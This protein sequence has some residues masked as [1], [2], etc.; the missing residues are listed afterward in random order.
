MNV[1][2]ISGLHGS[3]AFKKRH[4]PQV[5]AREAGI[6]FGLDSAAA[7]VTNDDVVAAAAEE[8]FTREKATGAFPKNA[9]AYCIR[10][11]GLEPERIDYLAHG[12]MFEP[13]RALYNAMGD[14]PRDQFYSV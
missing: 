10:P 12:W 1:L 11:G 13:L 9:I 14:Y 6:E 3:V 4:F 5:T 8:R 2:G 7:L